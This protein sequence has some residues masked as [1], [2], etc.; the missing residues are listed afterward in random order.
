MRFMMQYAGH[1]DYTKERRELFADLTI[2][3]IL[4]A[5]NERDRKIV[6]DDGE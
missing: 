3:D 6:A 1:G 5:L 4:N 2:D